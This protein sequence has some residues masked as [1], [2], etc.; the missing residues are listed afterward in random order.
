MVLTLIQRENLKKRTIFCVIAFSL[1]TSFQNIAKESGI[2]FYQMYFFSL[3]AMIEFALLYAFDLDR[4][5]IEK[6]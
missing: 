5:D 6:N 1:L 4:F 3:F 2:E